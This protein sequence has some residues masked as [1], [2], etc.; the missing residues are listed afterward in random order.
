MTTWL[1]V[2]G[3]VILGGTVS[4]ALCYRLGARNWLGWHVEAWWLAEKWSGR[5]WERAC[6]D[7]V[8]CWLDWLP[9]WTYRHRK[10]AESTRY[11]RKHGVPL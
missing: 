3:G 9:A 4:S 10:N 5:L 7:G 6:R 8:S 1:A 2:I 11:L